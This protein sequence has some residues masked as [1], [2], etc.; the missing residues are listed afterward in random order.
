VVEDETVNLALFRA[1]LERALDLPSF[2]IVEARDLRSARN[3]LEEQ[4]FDAVILDIRLPDGDGLDLA[5][6]ISATRSSGAG[7][8][9]IL[10]MSASVAVGD[11]AAAVAAGGDAFLGKP[12][13]PGQ[14]IAELTSLVPEFRRAAP[15]TTP[16]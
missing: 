1:V 6:E 13:L 14:L 11:R 2:L 5:R 4:D 12:F 16:A 15:V 9:R 10:I 8:P 7:R 3:A